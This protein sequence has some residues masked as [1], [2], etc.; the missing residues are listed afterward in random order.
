[1]ND[2]EQPSRATCK[3]CGGTVPNHNPSSLDPNGV[4]HPGHK[5]P[6]GGFF[7]PMDIAPGEF[8]LAHPVPTPVDGGLIMHNSLDSL[9]TEALMKEHADDW[10]METVREAALIC[11]NTLLAQKLDPT[12]V[13]DHNIEVL[14]DKHARDVAVLGLKH[15]GYSASAQKLTATLTKK[16]AVHLQAAIQ[17]ARE[18]EINSIPDQLNN[19]GD[20]ECYDLNHQFMKC[21][22]CYK[23]RRFQEIKKEASK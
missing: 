9:F 6:S 1:M 17:A 2:T 10:D 22:V 7:T 5:I 8:R 4:G 14:L 13:H 11:S 3:T 19:P 16:L 15:H 23:Q 18:D 20:Y 21:S 12:F